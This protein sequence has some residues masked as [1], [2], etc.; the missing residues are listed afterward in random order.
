MVIRRGLV[1]AGTPAGA[2]SCGGTVTAIAAANSLAITGATIP[3]GGSC[4]VTVSVLSATAGALHGY[5]C[6]RRRDIGQRRC[7]H[8]ARERNA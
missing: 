2:T 5:D 7:E 6:G 3:A 4:T 8:R 1:N